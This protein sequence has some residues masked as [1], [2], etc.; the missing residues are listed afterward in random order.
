MME[1]LVTHF[2]TYSFDIALHNDVLHDP[3]IK[4]WDTERNLSCA[5]G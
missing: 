3:N 5:S 4:R 2:I 1:Q